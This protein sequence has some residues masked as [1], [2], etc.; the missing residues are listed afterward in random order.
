M[1]VSF[2]RSTLQ[3]AQ[4]YIETVAQRLRGNGRLPIEHRNKPVARFLIVRAIENGVV[5]N[6]R[7][8]RKIHLRYQ[9]RGKRRTEERKMNVR[10]PPRII[11]I[12]PRIF[13]RTNRHESIPA[14]GVR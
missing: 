1:S 6:Q 12:S 5:R 14:F 9:T 13:A 4:N 8:A 11:V 3:S 2:H 7:I 10:R